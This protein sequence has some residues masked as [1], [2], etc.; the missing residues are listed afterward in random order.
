[1]RQVGERLG[2]PAAAAAT[3]VPPRDDEV[4]TWTSLPPEG[5]FRATDVADVFAKYWIFAWLF[6]TGSPPDRVTTAMQGAV[7]VQS[8]RIFAGD[9]VLSTLSENQRQA[10]SE[11]MIRTQ[12]GNMR[13][14]IGAGSDIEKVG[15]VMG[16]IRDQFQQQFGLDLQALAL[17]P[18]QG[19]VVGDR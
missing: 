4:R 3:L 9:K 1:M 18:D 13:Q 14:L 11:T 15:T 5:E 19:F 10:L 6:T 8:R 7:K 12:T 16:G 2:M 17:R